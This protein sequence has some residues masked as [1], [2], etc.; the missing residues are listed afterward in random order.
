MQITTKMAFGK[1][2][3]GFTI[4]EAATAILSKPVK[5]K[6]S[7]TAAVPKL[8]GVYSPPGNSGV[9]LALSI[10]KTPM[11]I[12][13]TNGRILATVAIFWITL[14]SCTPNR[15]IIAQQCKNYSYN[16]VFISGVLNS[17]IMPPK[18]VAKPT[19]MV[20]NA[21]MRVIHVKKPTS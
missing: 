18:A 17:G 9:K 13:N 11:P 10:K 1:F 14:K 15:F 2:F 16:N 3:A 4:S 6:N 5:V 20:E 8:P 19:P 7:I 21:I 12:N